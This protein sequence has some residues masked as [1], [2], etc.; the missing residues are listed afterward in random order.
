M[1]REIGAR[2]GRL[3]C[4]A[5]VSPA[6]FPFRGPA[7]TRS[8]RRGFTLL[9]LLA[10][11]GIIAILVGL[12]LP[13]TRRVRE[14]AAR[15]ACQNNLK[16]LIQALHNYEATGKPPATPSTALPDATGGR[17][18][19]PGCVGPGTLPEERLSWAVAV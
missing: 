3:V 11:I 19:P 9:E 2:P 1:G 18:L 13:A 14:S 5:S 10:V 17:F 12:L 15:L 16:Q 8:T 7:V 4:V 6:T